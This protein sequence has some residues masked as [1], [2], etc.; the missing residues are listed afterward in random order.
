MQLKY[1]LDGNEDHLEHDYDQFRDNVS[2]PFSVLP[3]PSWTDEIKVSFY[4][5]LV[6]YKFI[7]V[8]SQNQGT[9]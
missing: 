2:F 3:T 6:G 7:L 4:F 5:F 1:L 9:E 8:L